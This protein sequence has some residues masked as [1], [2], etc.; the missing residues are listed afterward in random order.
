MLEIIIQ[1][2]NLISLILVGICM[3]ALVYAIFYYLIVKVL[4]KND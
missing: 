4:F 2:A 3:G 1:G